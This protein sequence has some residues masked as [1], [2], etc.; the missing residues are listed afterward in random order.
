[1]SSASVAIVERVMWDG[2]VDAVVTAKLADIRVQD[3]AVSPGDFDTNLNE[4]GDKNDD[5]LSLFYIFLFSPCN[6]RSSGECG[7]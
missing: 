4:G 3:D 6:L 2:A 5:L 7:S 1:M